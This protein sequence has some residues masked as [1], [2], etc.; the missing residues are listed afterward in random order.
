[1]PGYSV[2][3]GEPLGAAAPDARPPTAPM[4]ALP[5]ISPLT[6]FPRRLTGYWIASLVALAILAVALGATHL[7]GT[8]LGAYIS[9]K[10]AAHPKPKECSPSR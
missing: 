2:R 1:L 7:R 3:V 10:C 8:Y 5:P 4:P 9:G 6:E